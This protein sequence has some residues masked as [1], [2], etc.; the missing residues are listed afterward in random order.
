MT[1]EQAN[2]IDAYANAKVALTLSNQKLTQLFGPVEVPRLE[3]S[4]KTEVKKDD[5]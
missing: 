1:Q 4:E 3:D 2:A 5:D